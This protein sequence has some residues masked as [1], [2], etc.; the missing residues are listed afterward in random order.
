MTLNPYIQSDNGSQYFQM[1]ERFLV[2]LYNKTSE[3]ENVDEAR[4]NLF[5][6][7]NRIIEKIP[8]TKQLKYSIQN[9]QHIKLVSGPLIN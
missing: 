5:C 9:M 7:R 6:H 3:Q 4:M 2:V 1:L 8:P